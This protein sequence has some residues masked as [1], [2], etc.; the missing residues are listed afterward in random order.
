MWEGK[1]TFD[2]RRMGDLEESEREGDPVERGLPVQ[3]LDADMDASSPADGWGKVWAMIGLACLV[4]VLI[5]QYLPVR[6]GEA[7]ER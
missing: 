2:C 1:A 7:R 6:R 5:A 4:G 3:V